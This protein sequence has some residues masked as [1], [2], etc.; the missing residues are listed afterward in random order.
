[1]PPSAY[2]LRACELRD[3]AQVGQ[4][5]RASF[6]ERPYTR[7]DFAYFLLVARDGF[8]V[9]S[10]DGSVMGYVIATARGR[11][12]SIQSIAVSPESREK[13]V[14]ELLL[15]SAID[16][17]AG[18]CGRVHLLVDAGNEAAIHLYR[19]LSFEETG[20]VVKGYYPNGGDA[21]E[22]VRKL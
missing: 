21:V 13:G 6:P 12:G 15:R 3:L 9:A 10:K 17:L 5:E 22:M 1:M 11:E 14:G 16:R 2:E 7:L 18:R 19:K 4:I 20:K 8:I